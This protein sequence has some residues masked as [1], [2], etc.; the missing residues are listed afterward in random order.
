MQ[1]SKKLLFLDVAVEPT[2]ARVCVVLKAGLLS[3]E[4]LLTLKAEMRLGD[5]VEIEGVL[6]GD[7]P[8]A[9]GSTVQ[10]IKGSVVA[11]WRQTNPGTWHA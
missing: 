3:V 8:V 7:F 1:V 9:D 11:K 2:E 6:E 5:V 4:D 10:C